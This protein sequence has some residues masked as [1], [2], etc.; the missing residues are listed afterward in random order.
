MAIVEKAGSIYED[1]LSLTCLSFSLSLNYHLAN[2][3][4]VT[5]KFSKWRKH[6]VG[7]VS[8]YLGIMYT[9]VCVV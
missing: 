8:I 3:Y 9:C 5:F 4:F 6:A 2:K 1:V 7:Y